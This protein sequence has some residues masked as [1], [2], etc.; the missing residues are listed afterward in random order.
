MAPY[1]T[2]TTGDRLSP[3]NIP[4][5][6]LTSSI[7][8][9]FAVN[10]S[11]HFCILLQ[12]TFSYFQLF[13]TFP[14]TH[15]RSYVEQGHMRFCNISMPWIDLCVFSCNPLKSSYQTIV[16]PLFHKS[17][18]CVVVL[19]KEFFLVQ[20]NC[21]F[22]QLSLL[23]LIQAVIP[24]LIALARWHKRCSVDSNNP[25]SLDSLNILCH[26]LHSRNIHFSF[27]KN[28]TSLPY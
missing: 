15:L 5:F 16:D 23:F 8:S 2:Q 21:T 22:S 20:G 24:I 1:S 17:V 26:S 19:L 6:T 28:L 3:W 11:L 13:Q 12:K 18:F 27:Y 25:P 9:P 4:L 7:S 10:D 14:C